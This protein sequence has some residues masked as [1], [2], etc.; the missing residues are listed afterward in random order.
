LDFTGFAGVPYRLRQRAAVACGWALAEHAGAGAPDCRRLIALVEECIDDPDAEGGRAP[1]S[2]RAYRAARD[3]MQDVPRGQLNASEAYAVQTLVRMA[4]LL[5][6]RP[7]IWT[8]AGAWQTAFRGLPPLIHRSRQSLAAERG[9]ARVV[10]G[11]VPASAVLRGLALQ[12]IGE[13]RDVAPG[14]VE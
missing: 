10:R 3:A 4:Q 8:P 9:L 5:V 7:E 12:G 11:V 1:V 6:L 2:S 14:V 13:R